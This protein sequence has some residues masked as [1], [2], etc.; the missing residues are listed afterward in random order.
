HRSLPGSSLLRPEPDAQGYSGSA[1]GARSVFECCRRELWVSQPEA[2]DQDGGVGG[3]SPAQAAGQNQKP[4][5]GRPRPHSQHWLDAAVR[6]SHNHGLGFFEVIMLA[7][8][9][10]VTAVW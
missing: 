6:G 9:F 10:L 4:R 2:V 8:L 3:D 5:T 1:G 7:Y